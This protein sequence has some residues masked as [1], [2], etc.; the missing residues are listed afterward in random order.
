MKCPKCGYHSFDYLN[1]CKKCN[2]DLV[3]FKAKYSLATLAPPPKEAPP[4]PEPTE[5]EPAEAEPVEPE[6]AEPLGAPSETDAAD[7]GFDF[8]NESDGEDPSGT[9]FVDDLLGTQD[10]SPPEAGEQEGETT[11]PEE[12]DSPFAPGD[13]PG[14]QEEPL[15]DLDWQ[16]ETEPAPASPAEEETGATLAGEPDDL[17]DLSWAEPPPEEEAAFVE[18]AAPEAEEDIFDFSIEEDLPEG[19]LSDS[20][21]EPAKKRE[22][23][24]GP[25][26][27]FDWE[28]APN[29]EGT[30]SE[31]SAPMEAGSEPESTQA[32][33]AEAEEVE[34]LP[35]AQD[36]PGA[37]KT[38]PGEATA[39]PLTLAKDDLEL[40]ID[41]ENDLPPLSGGE[42]PTEPSPTGLEH[43]AGGAFSAM[44][45]P[46]AP[47]PIEASPAFSPPP[48]DPVDGDVFDFEPFEVENVATQPEP[49][50]ES[51]DGTGPLAPSAA[52][53]TPLAP[54]AV[55]EFEESIP[56]DDDSLPKQAEEEPPASEAEDLQEVAV[57]PPEADPAFSPPAEDPADDTFDFE[58]FEVE[59]RAP[60]DAPPAPR[61]GPTDEP[62]GDA[63]PPD[64]EEAE[65]NL[66]GADDL[67][68]EEERDGSFAPPCEAPSLETMSPVAPG[69]LLPGRLVAGALDLAILAVIFCLFL[70]AGQGLLLPEQGAL[71]LPSAPALLELSVPYFLLLF[72][73]SFGYFTLFHFLT[74]QTIGKMLL[75]LRVEGADG[76]PLLFSQAFL[77]SAGGLLSLL[78]AGCG[79]LAVIFDGEGRGWNDRLAGS[80]VRKVAP[81]PE[82]TE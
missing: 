29:R 15:P 63:A 41:F 20:G 56:G 13:D 65:E 22:P 51:I 75:K 42:G 70:A 35:P 28:G 66:L 67:V 16:E 14:E 78:P 11:R 24:E 54:A 48:E 68:A 55:A 46:I 21:S 19:D 49:A 72:A 30:P 76:E 71:Q 26:D 52:P 44:D 45:E 82:N 57:A 47:F 73:V 3:T 79:Y 38:E 23:E 80:R 69:A 59:P 58:P 25:S 39:Q 64:P 5:P 40:L 60:E 33:A 77:R 43:L 4:E 1:S 50:D 6:P 9:A 36:E 27:P 8:Q 17:L 2:G 32:P 81:A 12:E 18:T 61:P 31:P 53:G 7:F 10:D 37:T 34:P 62:S 74:G